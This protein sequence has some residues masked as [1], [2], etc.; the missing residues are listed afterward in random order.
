MVGSGFGV[1]YA[2][3]VEAGM[4]RRG[5]GSEARA[6]QFVVIPLAGVATGLLWCLL[7]PERHE[8]AWMKWLLGTGAL[9]PLLGCVSIAILRDTSMI[10]GIGTSIVAAGVVSLS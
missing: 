4:Q 10:A 3:G 9:L 8:R 6:L 1:A 5:F 2:I 7:G